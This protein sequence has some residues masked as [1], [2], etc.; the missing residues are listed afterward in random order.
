MEVLEIEP[1]TSLLVAIH[2]DYLPNE[3][4]FFWTYRTKNVNGKFDLTDISFFKG[5]KKKKKKKIV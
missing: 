5:G 3:A 4:V 2:T 1:A